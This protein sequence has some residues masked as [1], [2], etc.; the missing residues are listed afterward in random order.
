MGNVQNNTILFEEETVIQWIKDH[1]QP[2]STIDPEAPFTDLSTFIHRLQDTKV[3]GFGESTRGARSAHQM[4]VMKHRFL[5]FMVEKLEF[6][7][8]ALEL[9]W[10]IGVEL[11]EYL[12]KGIGNPRTILFNAWG[13]LQ[14]EEILA[15]IQWMRLYNE[16]NPNDAIQVFGGYSSDLHAK[17]FDVVSNYVRLCALER[18]VEIDIHYSVLRSADI[19]N[20]EIQQVLIHH[21][22]LAY[23][24]VSSLPIQEGYDLVLQYARFILCFYEQQTC[25]KLNLDQ[26]FYKSMILWHEHTGNQI[27]YWGGIGHTAANN[28]L[29]NGESVGS[30]LR[31]HLGVGY[32]SIGLTFHHGSGVDLIPSPSP[33]FAEAILGAVDLKNYFLDI[34]SQQPKS[35]YA[36]LNS[37][38]KT[39]VIGPY[40]DKEKDADFHMT[41][42]LADWFDIIIHTQEIT[43][44]EI[45]TK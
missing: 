5:R 37:P 18:I 24:L 10:L 31:K 3:V 4:Y 35:V 20:K 30:H 44:A 9:H 42:V 15:A 29:A 26:K 33:D 28:I 27:V 22:K 43:P 2:L 6:R 12:R 14:T 36:W 1:A 7:S 19:K 41:G 13:P 16:Q 34:R 45:L 39:R 17:V 38:T 11:N 32:I 25:D 23:E 40:Y 8:L 21:A